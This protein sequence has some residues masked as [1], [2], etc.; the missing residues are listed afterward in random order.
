MALAAWTRRLHAQEQDRPSVRNSGNWQARILHRIARPRVGQVLPS[1]GAVYSAAP[2]LAVWRPT[3]PLRRFSRVAVGVSSPA[4]S[5]SVPALHPTAQT[6]RGRLDA[7]ADAD[8]QARAQRRAVARWDAGRLRRRRCGHRGRAQRVGQP[9]PRRRRRRLRQPA[10]D[11]QRQIVER[12]ALVARRQDDRLPR[13]A[14]GKAN[15]WRIEVAGGEAE[16]IT[17]EKGGISAFGWSP[18]GR[19]SRS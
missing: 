1:I 17:D 19:R 9:D 5:P 8:R 16:Q 10:A 3:C 4:S 13:R 18:D 15:I 2:L 14:S 12:A 7:R 11:P 6:P